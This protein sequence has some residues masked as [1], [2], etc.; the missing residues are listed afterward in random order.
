MLPFGE[1]LVELAGLVPERAGSLAEG[2]ALHVSSLH[3]TLPIESRIGPAGE[4]SASLPR[5]RLATGFDPPL[6]AVTLRFEVEQ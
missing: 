2:V 1:L 3:L 5:G 4:L 6:T